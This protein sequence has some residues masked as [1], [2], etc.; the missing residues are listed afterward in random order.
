MWPHYLPAETLQYSPSA[1]KIKSSRLWQNL[2][3]LAPRATGLP[4]LSL[5]LTR[6]SNS[7]NFQVLKATNGYFS[8]ASKP[9]CML[10]S[11]PQTLFPHLIPTW[12]LVQTFFFRKSYLAAWVPLSS[13]PRVPWLLPE[14]HQ[15]GL[16]ESTYFILYLTPL[17]DHQ[18]WLFYAVFYPQ[19]LAH[20]RSS[21]D[22][23]WRT[24]QMNKS[25]I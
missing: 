25:Q 3:Y 16:C 9:S 21:V 15:A 20:G 4:H 5:T 23:C 10:L 2:C 22:T 11:L 12:P 14:Q 17:W 8:F 18:L 7:V 19:L 13:V 1:F 6:S 24:M